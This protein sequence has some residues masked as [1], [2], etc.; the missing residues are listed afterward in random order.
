MGKSAVKGLFYICLIAATF[1]LTTI[2]IMAAFSGNVAPVDSV[3]MPL[4]G[5]AVPVLLIVNLI[6]ALC[7]ALAV[8]AGHWFRWWHSS[9]TG[10]I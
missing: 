9:A 3:I 6:T 1:V 8:S 2:T 4:L 5:L 10:D 7:W